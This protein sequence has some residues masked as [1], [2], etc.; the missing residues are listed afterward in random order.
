MALTLG[1]SANSHLLLP[2]PDSP[3]WTA[4]ASPTDSS[5]HTPT[6]LPDCCPDHSNQH[7][8]FQPDEPPTQNQIRRL[9][10]YSVYDSSGNQ[11]TLSSLFTPTSLRKHRILL[12]FIRNFFCG[13]CQQFLLTLSSQLPAS[14]LPA[15]TAV[16]VIGCGA[17][18]LLPSYLELTHCPYPIYTDP[19]AQLYD[20][21][22]MQ[23]SWSLGNRAPEYIRQSLFMG[24]LKS[25]AQGLKRVPAGDVRK[26]GEMNQNGGEFLFVRTNSGDSSS[27]A[28]G[29]RV[30]WCH[31][32]RNTRDH[33][34][35]GRLREVLGMSEYETQPQQVEKATTWAPRMPRE[36]HGRRWTKPSLPGLPQSESEGEKAKAKSGHVRRNTFGQSLSVKSHNVMRTL[37][38]KRPDTAGSWV[39]RDIETQ[40]RSLTPAVAVPHLPSLSTTQQYEE[41]QQQQHQ[42]QQPHQHKRTQSK[43]RAAAQI[44]NLK[45][46][47][48]RTTSAHA[49]KQYLLSD[50]ISESHV[51]LVSV[52]SPGGYSVRSSLTPQVGSPSPVGTPLI[53]RAGAGFGQ[54]VV[55]V[56]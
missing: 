55:S 25:I 53:G 20:K 22:G 9:A 51:A 45:I 44:L 50:N 47:S 23:R 18:S 13:N 28:D 7:D 3:T 8:L 52:V 35:V 15:D 24:G 10:G 42:T 46:T 14:A 36:R 40:K 16:A 27:W 30:E 32:M 17:P 29:W 43:S 11:H 39:G 26:A 41:Q 56:R 2:L 4:S 6:A 1:P 21:L 19:T 48:G 5:P 49:A 12:I 54:G 33:T 37:S 31:R 34:E 38:L